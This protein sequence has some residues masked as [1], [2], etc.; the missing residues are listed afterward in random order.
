MLA[1]TFNSIVCNTHRFKYT[2][3]NNLSS[4]VNTRDVRNIG[5]FGTGDLEVSL[6]DLASFEATKHL[7]TEAYK[8]IG[9]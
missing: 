3:P 7:I 2:T 6:N 1:N 4:N 9:G 5:H 8:N